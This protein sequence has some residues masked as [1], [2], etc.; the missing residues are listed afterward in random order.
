MEDVFLKLEV[1]EK[2]QA[3]IQNT[4][5]NNLS[6]VNTIVYKHGTVRRMAK[7]EFFFFF[8]FFFLYVKEYV[9][10]TPELICTAHTVEGCFVVFWSL[11]L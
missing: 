3:K 4:F 9:H 2:R 11:H 5:E 1:K 7:I 10:T 6:T 8:F